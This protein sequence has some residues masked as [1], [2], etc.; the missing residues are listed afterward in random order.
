MTG[1]G[2]LRTEGLGRRFGGLVAVEDVSVIFAA[3]E[4]SCVIGPNGAGK[5]TLLNMICGAITPSSGRILFDGK[6]I[7]GL[8]RHAI[9]RAGIARKF[10]VPSIFGSLTV[11]ENLAL[12]GEGD[13]QDVMTRTGLYAERDTRADVLAH[14][15]KQWLEIGMGLIRQPRLLLLD[16]PTAGLSPEETRAVADL[17]LS[18][19]GICTVVVIDHDMHFV[20]A[21]SARTVVMHQG[22]LVAEGDFATIERDPMVRDIYLGRA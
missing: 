6:P 8:S 13:T 12:A 15:Q 11:A 10:Q 2:E 5:S 18:L 21:L 3:G 22:R 19:R 16:E 4:V 1:G 14:G 9:A 20:R 17:L 7:E